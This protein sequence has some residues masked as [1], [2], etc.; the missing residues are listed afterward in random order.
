M[1]GQVITTQ[2]LLNCVIDKRGRHY[3][4]DT[5]QSP[6]VKTTDPEVICHEKSGISHVPFL[7][8]Y[9]LLGKCSSACS[10]LTFSA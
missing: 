4:K 10:Q 9:V 5:D 1:S 6:T 2:F 7:T 8:F 3:I